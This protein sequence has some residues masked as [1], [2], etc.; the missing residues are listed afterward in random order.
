MSYYSLR[1]LLTYCLL[2][3]VNNMLQSIN[4]ASNF[5]WMWNV[6]WCSKRRTSIAR[7]WI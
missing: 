2:I 7:A 4:F 3:N 6:V 5:V 1:K